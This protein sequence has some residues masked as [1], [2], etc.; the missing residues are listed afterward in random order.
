MRNCIDCGAE[1]FECMGSVIAGSFLDFING[2]TDKID[3]LCPKCA[4]RR[5]LTDD[6]PKKKL[7]T[8]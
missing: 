6:L 1:I 5:V 2:K 7:D 4:T 8:P 3:E